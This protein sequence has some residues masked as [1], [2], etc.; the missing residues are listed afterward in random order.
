MFHEMSQI[1]GQLV[2]TVKAQQSLALTYKLLHSENHIVTDF[3]GQYI[4]QWKQHAEHVFI[5]RRE[6]RALPLSVHGNQGLTCLI[7]LKLQKAWRKMVCFSIRG[8]RGYTRCNSFYT[9]VDSVHAS[10]NIG[11]IQA[12]VVNPPL[13]ILHPYCLQIKLCSSKS[14]FKKDVHMKLDEPCSFSVSVDS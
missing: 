1:L 2:Y 5:R 3:L 12:F 7:Y 13:V 6:R 9:Y 10:E 4:R 8:K 14:T 11:S